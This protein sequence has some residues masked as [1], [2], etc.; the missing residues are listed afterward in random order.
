MTP[1]RIRERIKKALGMGA[2]EEKRAQEEPESSGETARIVLV[3]P[4]DRRQELAAV[5]VGQS[6]LLSTVKM[7][8]PLGSGCNDSTC[9][10]CRFEVLAGEDLLSA[11]SDREMTTLANNSRPGHLRLGCV[12]AVTKPGTLEI[13]GYEFL[14]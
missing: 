4:G 3:G 6:V 13:R 2:K 10:T 7:Q 5:P 14:E 11:R 9:S 8:K 1:F 12:A